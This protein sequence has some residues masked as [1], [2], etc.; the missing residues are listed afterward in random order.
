METDRRE[1][2]K[3]MILLAKA[4]GYLTDAQVKDHL[5]EDMSDPEQLEG[6][7]SMLHDMDFEVYDEVPKAGQ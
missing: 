6:I 4:Q 2:L 7:V 5:S 3:A 1:N